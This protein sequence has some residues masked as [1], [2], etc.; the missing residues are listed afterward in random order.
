MNA[1]V[2]GCRSIR[3]A[4]AICLL[5]VSCGVGAASGSENVVVLNIEPSPENPRNS[6]GAFTALPSGR[7]LFYYTQFY[8]GARDESPARIVCIQSDDEGRTWSAPRV[9]IENSGR[10]NV[11]S[12]SLLRLRSGK[13]ALFYLVKNS[14]IDCR[15]YVR[16]SS[17]DGATWSEARVVGAAPGYFV[18]N[19]DR[20]VQLESGRIVVPV[21]FHRSRGA[22]PETAKSFDPRALAIWFYSD[23][24]GATWREASTWWALG[25]VSGSGLQEPGVVELG[26]GRLFSWARTDRGAQFGFTSRDRGVT[27]TPPSRTELAS[28][29]SPASIKRWP[30]S[31]KLIAVFNDHSGR[32]PFVKGKRTP[33]VAAISHDDGATWPQR[34]ILEDDP[35][36]WYCYT[37]MHF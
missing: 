10:N 15:P 6:E 25:E 29:L 30:G 11:M 17:D 36:G 3:W 22:D 12:V 1:V 33:L 7:V 34:V 8:G 13:L 19:N 23:D 2:R 27:W 16:Y 4:A 35:D 18:L 24:D 5:L 37:A 28:P 31:S 9:V 26:D 14:W 20:V 21:A 32:F